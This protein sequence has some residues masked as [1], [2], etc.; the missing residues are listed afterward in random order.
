M[1]EH[2]N[3]AAMS[4]DELEALAA[5]KRADEKKEKEKQLRFHEKKKEA[6][7]QATVVGCIDIS[8]TMRDLK[9]EV[10]EHGQEIILNAYELKGQEPKSHKSVSIIS[11]DR[12]SKVEIQALDKLV[13]TEFTAVAIDKIKEILTRKFASRNKWQ[14]RVVEALLTKNKAGEYDGRL[15]VKLR[16]I[17]RDGDDPELLKAID[18]LTDS[19]DVAGVSQ[20]CRVYHRKSEKD[21]WEHINLQFSTI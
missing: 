1:T 9:K 3:V 19:F 13:P 21:K 2:L 16:S 8:T 14:W 11:E 18:E 12:C 4:A 5:S 20:Y 6:Y 17:A 15:L 10:I 7:L